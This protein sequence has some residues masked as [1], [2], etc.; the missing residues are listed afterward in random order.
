MHDISRSTPLPS[1][2]LGGLLLSLA[3]CGGGG[4]GAPAPSPVPPP[5][6]NAAPQAQA[7][8]AQTVRVATP[9]QLDGRASSDADGDPLTYAWTLD[10]RPA[11]SAAVLD[12]PTAAAPR[13]TPDR[14]GAFVA[15]LV[16]HDGRSASAAARVTVTA[17]AAQTAPVADAGPDQS[18]VTGARVRL[19]AA[20]SRDADGDALSYR[21]TLRERPAGSQAALA[22]A[23]GVAPT[24]VV[25]AAG[26]YVARVVV[27]DGTQDS[28]PVDVAV[29]ADVARL[30][31][32][33]LPAAADFGGVPVGGTA[34]RVLTLRNTGNGTLSFRPGFPATD[35]GVWRMGG[36]S[37][38]GTLA[39]GASCTVTVNFTPGNAQAY[40]G[41]VEIGFQELPTGQGGPRVALAGVGSG[42]VTRLATVTPATADFGSVPLGMTA[43]RVFTLH[44]AG[45]ERLTFRPGYPATD[46]APWSLGARSCLAALDPGQSC[47]VTVNFA[48]GNSQRYSGAVRFYFNELQDGQGNPLASLAGE[49]Q[50]AL[51]LAATM[52]PAEAD[53]GGVP[54]GMTAERVFTLVNTGN[55]PLRLRAGSPGAEGGPWSVRG[56]SCVGEL[57]VGGRCTV[58]VGF[59]PVNS[60]DYT[61][62][63]FVHFVE[64][65]ID[66]G[67]VRAVL[68][69]RGG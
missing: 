61:G 20:A 26:R 51:A 45:A 15:T 18:V 67:S 2:L 27:N 46:G 21:W 40:T 55:G 57:P 48:P 9:V 17:V 4:G 32:Q 47:T 53:F 49:G 42:A 3:A 35:G 23:D 65:P 12:Q 22:G 43:S 37:C 54:V 19:S 28:A 13:F 1:T 64:L 24:F 5:P 6:V 29:Q 58:T 16:V 34:S 69:G 8:T 11:G 14:A 59:T 63:A 7:G 62:A 31:A 66:Q 52:T 38:T 30:S 50:G 39:P 44:N 25:D 10:T 33:A 41:S 56:G 36:R 68:R 60:Q